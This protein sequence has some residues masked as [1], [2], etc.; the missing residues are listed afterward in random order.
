MVIDSMRKLFPFFVLS[1]FWTVSFG[2]ETQ[3]DFR[4]TTTDFS[5]NF[6]ESPVHNI[7]TVIQ[8][9]LILKSWTIPVSDSLHFFV[10][11][12]DRSESDSKKTSF[13]YEIDRLQYWVRA[14]ILQEKKERLNGNPAYNFTA[15][16][17][18]DTY[19]YLCVLTKN[20]FFLV[21]VRFKGNSLETDAQDFIRSF[22]LN[23]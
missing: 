3:L 12:R 17:S 18:D 11:Q 23:K 14:E 4:L 10:V 20:H 9:G 22:Q 15:T 16:T 19:H 2:Q 13:Q 8:T 5:I 7:D 6:P 1:F 21:G